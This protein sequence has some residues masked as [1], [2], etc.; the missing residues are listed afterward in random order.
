M[1]ANV[2]MMGPERTRRFW[3][4]HGRSSVH[5]TLLHAFG[6]N[7]TTAWTPEG[8]SMWY[9]LS[10]GGVR[11]VLE[12]FA[13]CGIVCRTAHPADAF[14]W[15]G[16]QDWAVPHDLESRAIVRDR[17]ISQTCEPAAPLWKVGGR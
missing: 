2:S 12:E 16:A 11:E 10:V 14:V 6:N 17:W 7:P 8:L 4:A 15:N 3:R 13:A 9:G 1:G 5:L